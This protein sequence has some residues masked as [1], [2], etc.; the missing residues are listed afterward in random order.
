MPFSTKS[1]SRSRVKGF[2]LIELL[3][4]I[5]IIAILVAL[6]LPAVQSAREAARR[7]ECKNKLKQIGIA[8]HNYHGTHGQFPGNAMAG[9]S[10]N[11]SG[12]YK[13]AW[14]SWSGLAMLLPFID[15]EALYTKANFDYRWDSNAG[16]TVNLSQVSNVPVPQF[17]CPSDP[18]SDRRYSTGRWAPTSY[19]ISTGPASNWSMR[20]NPPGFATLWWGS[21]IK[22]ITDG[23]SNTLAGS[24]Q[25]IGLNTGRW[26]RNQRPRSFWHRVVIGGRLQR[27]NNTNGR[28]WTNSQAHIN[29]IN[30]YYQNRCIARYDSGAGWNS[31]SD[32]QGRNWASGRTFWGP[33]NTT[34]IG[35]NVGPSCDVDSSVTDMDIKEPSSH[36]P[37]GVH[38][39]LA[40]GSV[41]FISDSINQ[42]SWIALGSIAGDDE[43]GEY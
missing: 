43:V 38:G 16:G 12:R 35:P 36:H 39:L 42:A 34:L 41:R 4:V 24:E 30:A 10:E 23:T 2:T 9:T 21:K 17:V 1:K 31:A 32:E 18:G 29:R 22:D 14:L 26:D 40:D 27:A 6:L 20:S 13:Q 3:V 37:G 25:Q 15:Q 28:K 7:S 11:T 8:L 19:T 5:A 33:W